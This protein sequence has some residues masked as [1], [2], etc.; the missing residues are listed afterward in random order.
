MKD[1]GQ[2]EGKMMMC[3]RKNHK[4]EGREVEGFRRESE[5]IHVFLGTE[6]SLHTDSSFQVKL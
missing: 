4:E 6:V 3:N 1:F 2:Q 5:R